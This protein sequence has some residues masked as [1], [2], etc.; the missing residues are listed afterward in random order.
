M[1]PNWFLYLRN[2][3]FSRCF[4][5]WCDVL[6]YFL[7]FPYVWWGADRWVEFWHDGLEGVGGVEG[8]VGCGKGVGC[9]CC[10][11]VYGSSIMSEGNKCQLGWLVEFNTSFNLKKIDRNWYFE[12]TYNKNR[13][14]LLIPTLSWLLNPLPLSHRIQAL[15]IPQRALALAT[16]FMTTSQPLRLNSSQVAQSV[17]SYWSV[18][19][20]GVTLLKSVGLQINTELLR[21]YE[22]SISS[23]SHTISS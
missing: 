8:C 4:I 17:S 5:I 20:R 22:V 15:L 16:G 3:S 14:C 2:K 19:T 23:L 6:R 11:F 10:H 18:Q 12:L 9:L 13:S 1:R 21:V 7:P